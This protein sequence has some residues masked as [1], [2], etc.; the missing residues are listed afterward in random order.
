MQNYNVNELVA[1]IQASSAPVVLFGASD[2]GELALYAL[3]KRGVDV[4]YFCDSNEQKQG[5][6][7]FG[8]PVIPPQKLKEC[9]AN[10]H[11]FISS[12]SFTSIMPQLDGIG[13][14]NYYNCLPLFNETDFSLENHSIQLPQIKRRIA[15]HANA[16]LRL[17]D[18]IIGDHLN[19]AAMDVVVTEACSL[20][21]IDCS[22]LM[23]YYL[24]PKNSDMDELSTALDQ[25]MA[26]VDRVGEVRVL[27]GEPFMNKKVHVAINKLASFD[28]IDSIVVY[29]NGTIVPKDENL[30]CLRNDRVL[31]SITNYGALSRNHDHLVELLES[32]GIA[33]K[34]EPPEGWTDS[35]RIKYRERSPEE[36][37]DM[38][39]KC[40]V[41]DV[42]TVLNGKL[43]RCPFS[44]NGTNLGA[45]PF[46]PTDEINLIAEQGD[47]SSLRQEVV[48]L[49]HGKKFLTACTYCNGR[50]F[51]TPAVT[52][53]VQTKMP[54]PLEKIFS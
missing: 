9:P 47:T 15:L 17:Q 39:S 52:P 14:S 5:T 54:L 49:F 44:A 32:E 37:A 28:Q 23:Q 7:Y 45:I 30:E 3:R 53:G 18:N 43:Y 24:K 29:T 1:S 22:N 2:Y 46:D 4:Q 26:V 20:K 50:D 36:L 27:G 33:F 51:R 11:V 35:G 38:F 12:N 21:C 40:C 42:M 41:R 48:E 10:V 8:V 13:V 25:L 31:L 16:Y 19:L 6:R 34:T